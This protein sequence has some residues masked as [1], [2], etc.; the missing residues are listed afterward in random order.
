ML[1]YCLRKWDE[2]KKKLEEELL[3]DPD[4]N[5]C[6]YKHIVEKVVEIILNTNEE[7]IWSSADITEID[8]GD[9]QGTLLF[10]IPRKTYQ[11]SEYEYLMTYVGYGSC[12]ECDALQAIQDYGENPISEDQLKDFMALC[13]DI[14][15]NMIKPYNYGWRNE[16][17]FTEVEFDEG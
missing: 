6:D 16:E 8:D 10:L 2:N 17:E 12:S 5:N 3:K 4:L 11:P 14:I 9:Y 13:K 7:Y 1:K 15:T